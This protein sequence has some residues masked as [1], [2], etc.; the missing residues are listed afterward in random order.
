MPSP[1]IPSVS[2]MTAPKPPVIRWEYTALPMLTN[3]T[4]NIDALNRLGNAG[5]ELVQVM[6]D[7]YYLKRRAE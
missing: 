4:N 2:P 3:E 1:R 7:R 6:R 5:W